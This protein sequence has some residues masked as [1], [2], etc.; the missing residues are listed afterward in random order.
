MT[1]NFVV[2]FAEA[3]LV[4]KTFK[5]YRNLAFMFKIFSFLY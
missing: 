2:T 4:K 1:S 3:D 5:K